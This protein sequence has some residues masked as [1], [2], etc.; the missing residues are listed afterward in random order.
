MI[1]AFETVL[2][3]VAAR[4][5]MYVGRTSLRAVGHYLAGYGHALMDLGQPDPQENWFRWVEMKFLISHS[6]WHWTRI[7]LHMYGS[8]RAAIDALPALHAE[9]RGFVAQHG[10]E[11]INAEHYRRFVAAYGELV[12]E[13]NEKLTTPD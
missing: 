3:A 8:D 11:S 4:P 10:A 2:A 1:G 9:Y 6:A 7:L 12:H 5:G 13:P